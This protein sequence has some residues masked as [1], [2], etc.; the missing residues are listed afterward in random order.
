MVRIAL[1]ITVARLVAFL[2][3]LLGRR[4]TSLPGYIAQR[5]APRLLET[6]LAGLDSCVIVTGTN[7]K[8]TTTA[9]LYAVLALSQAWVCNVGGA[10]LAQGLTAV[11]SA[12]C[13]PSLRPRIP[14][15][16][17]EVDEA[18]L[19]RVCD[20]LAAAGVPTTIVITNVFR[21]QLDR[22]GEVDLA[23]DCLRRG[24][25]HPAFC[26]VANADDPLVASLCVGRELTS[27][28]GLAEFDE[29]SPTADDARDGTHCLQCGAPLVW[30]RVAY[31]QLG[32]Y[33]CSRCSFARP[34][35]DFVGMPGIAEL[36]IGERRGG[37]TWSVPLPGIGLYNAY[38]ALAAAAAA[39]V[40]GISPRM[41][42]QGAARFVPPLGRGQMY[43][44]R[45]PTTLTLIKNPTGAMSVLQALT[46]QQGEKRIVFAIND[47]DAD[48]RDVSWLWDI[49]LERLIPQ[50]DCAEFHCS[51][52]RA[53]D[54]AVRLA[55]AGVARERIR[56]EPE[57]AACV[58]FADEVETPCFVLA[59]Y[60]ALAPCA[61]LLEGRPT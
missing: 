24:I 35:P 38:N 13:R 3:R 51:G 20:A 28:Y 22:Y 9:V 60:T 21:D 53:Q 58:T 12:N 26:V 17:L 7:G 5:I 45:A 57:L 41:V 33:A 18:T 4:A 23:L 14:R 6:S 39:R 34:S 59:T 32:H 40:L 54:M 36:A 27:M 11:L 37:E 48:G 49:D 61:Q 2:L 15:A 19:P 46:S 44:R 1:A 10:N 8:T 42:A 31:G 43:A 16:L 56:V 55:Y 52:Q 47:A 25:R 30:Q 50:L 29:A